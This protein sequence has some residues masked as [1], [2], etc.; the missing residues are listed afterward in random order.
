MGRA[1]GTCIERE[2]LRTICLPSG[3]RETG[4]SL[5]LAIPRGIPMIVMQSKIPVAMW[6]QAQATSRRR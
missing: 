4:I 2:G 6:S 1:T 5:K 3:I